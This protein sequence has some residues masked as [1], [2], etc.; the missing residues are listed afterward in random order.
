MKPLSQTLANLIVLAEEAVTRPNFDRFAF[1]ERL[2]D[3]A[4]A[5]RHAAERPAENIRT[6]SAALVMITALE[7]IRFAHPGIDTSRWLMLA[8]V[9]LPL[10]RSDA[11]AA[12]A[13]ERGQGVD[14]G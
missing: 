13:N 10:L 14:R 5:V 7:E 4:Q 12:F 8:G 11:F 2:L 6:T 9:A 1:G 3:L